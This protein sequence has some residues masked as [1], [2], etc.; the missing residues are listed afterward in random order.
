ME[1]VKCEWFWFFPPPPPL[2]SGF[3]F[4]SSCL[5]DIFLCFSEANLPFQGLRGSIY[6]VIRFNLVLVIFVQILDLLFEMTGSRESPSTCL[7]PSCAS[8]TKRVKVWGIIVVIE[9]AAHNLPHPR[10]S[11]LSHVTDW[12]P[13]FLS[14]AGKENQ[15]DQFDGVRTFCHLILIFSLIDLSSVVQLISRSPFGLLS[16][17]TDTWHLEAL[18][19]WT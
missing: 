8:W 3:W 17:R 6:E 1:L 7:Q 5:V 2:N 16:R 14:L 4:S 9:Q 11:S 10:I 18:S 13:T 19:S 12:T 15:E